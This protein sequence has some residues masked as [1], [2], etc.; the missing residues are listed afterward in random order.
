M[1]VTSVVGS[2]NCATDISNPTPVYVGQGG[3]AVLQCGFEDRRLLWQV[4][5]GD[6]STDPVA[7]GDTT[8]DSS[9]YS[10]S[11]NPLT[12]LYY[13]LHILNVGMSDLKKYRCLT[14][15]NGIIKNFYLKLDLLGTC[16]C[17]YTLVIF[18]MLLFLVK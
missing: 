10:V 17:N 6:G 1:H 5:N 13:R 14:N 8:I 2:V 9:K 4:Y 3:E 16:T 18:K 7:G 15:V 12:E 11:K